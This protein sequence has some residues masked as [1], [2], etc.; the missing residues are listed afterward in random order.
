MQADLAGPSGPVAVVVMMAYRLAAVPP[1]AV[2]VV[3]LG[4]DAN[5][6]GIEER[7]H[8]VVQH[9][10]VPREAA[11]DALPLAGRDPPLVEHELGH[12]GLA[13]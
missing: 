9:D 10:A 1:A 5:G 12:G 2:P 4:D 7:G 13:A 11:L 3:D 8:P 6:V